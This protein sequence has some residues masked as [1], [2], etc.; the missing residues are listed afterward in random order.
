MGLE[1]SFLLSAVPGDVALAVGGAYAATAI[2]A[3]V[4]LWKQ[5]KTDVAQNQANVERLINS[6][7]ATADAMNKLTA[8]LEGGRTRARYP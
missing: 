5:H 8:T 6:A 2:V 1:P 4:A 7:H 3:I